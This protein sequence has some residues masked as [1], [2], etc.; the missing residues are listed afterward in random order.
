MTDRLF[1]ET[2][3]SLPDSVSET[4]YPSQEMNLPEEAPM[5]LLMAGFAGAG[6]TTL[7]KW[8]IEQLDKSAASYGSES[9]K[10]KILSKD[11]L[12]LHHLRL[13]EEVKQAGWNAFEDLFKNLKEEV[14]EKRKS[15][16]IDTSNEH[17][18][19]LDHIIQVMRQLEQ[20]HIRP[21]LRVILCVANKE[22]RANRLRERGSEFSPFVENLPEIVDDS[23][24][25]DRFGH[26]LEGF[27][28]PEHFKRFSE[29]M[30]FVKIQRGLAINT[31]LQVEVYGEF[32]LKSLQSFA[33]D[34]HI[35][36]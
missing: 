15:V 19:V 20:H 8:L 9:S 36:I 35:I 3:E 2:A 26:L 23:E 10:W 18:F 6:K 22:T 30:P 7:A 27:P 5:L 31:T 29:N 14:F 33:K 25:E 11:H 24:L 1:G 12:K 4:D 32:V 28:L 21:Y 13:G 34:N 17:P 16:I